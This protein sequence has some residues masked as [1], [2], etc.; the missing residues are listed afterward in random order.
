MP[1]E[2][3][4]PQEEKKESF[5][6]CD[7]EAANWSEFLV[8]GLTDGKDFHS[9]KTLDG[10]FKYVFSLKR[11]STKI[12]AHFGG[13]Y[14]FLFLL[15]EAFSHKKYK[16][17]NIIGRGSSILCFDV[18]YKSRVISFHDS[19]AFLPFSLRRLC[20]NFNVEH[21]KLNINYSKITRV[22]KK[23]ITYLEHDC[24]GLHQVIEKYRS[25]DLI[26]QAG[27]KT[28]TASQSLQIFRL[29]LKEK[30]PSLQ[31]SIDEFVRS[32]YFGGRTE[33]FRP[34]YYPKKNQDIMKRIEKTKGRG[35]K[36]KT[37][38]LLKQIDPIYCYDVNSLYPTVMRDNEFPTQFKKRTKKYEPKEMGFYDVKVYVPE[39]IYIPPLGVVKKVGKTEKFIFPVGTFRGKWSTIE[40][41]Y[42]RSL[43]V[44][45]LEVYEG[46]IFSSGGFIFRD[47]I[48]HL[49][50]VRLKA[51][52]QKNMVDDILAKLCMNST[53]GR[54]GLNRERTNLVE[55]EGQLGV[56]PYAEIKTKKGVVRLME[57]DAYLEKTFSNVAIAAWVTSLARIY[58]HK[59]YMVA[60]L[61][62]F[63]TD[64]DSLLTTHKYQA[65]SKGLGALKKEYEAAGAVFLLPKTYCVDHIFNHP[66][67]ISKKVVMKGFDGKKIK[68][69]NLDQ[70]TQALEGELRALKT[71]TPPRLARI[72]TALKKGK[73]LYMTEAS[74]REIR[75][76]YDKRLIKKVGKSYSSL[77]L[78]ISE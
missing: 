66:D 44:E 1:L 60:P 74:S 59:I 34:Y 46:M 6:V 43:G 3:L 17:K 76:L 38:K 71:K 21:K 53:Y 63:Y 64:T 48:N 33:I 26:K 28:T 40:L 10:F 73:L 50:D 69:F 42:A 55:D 67:E 27:A 11:E 37:Q 68:R 39:T 29:F 41:E 58:M 8:I 72:K 78:V 52:E 18:I 56:K 5:F 7:I 31:D 12:Y 24:K 32:A 45:I 23:L 51:K 20:E 61:K 57:E 65:D 75:S 16:V 9:F 22:T 19:C 62:L 47:F 2:P 14:D 25:W 13:G 36:E 54:F 4:Q 49:Y 30:I 15:G 70:F 35:K 77:P